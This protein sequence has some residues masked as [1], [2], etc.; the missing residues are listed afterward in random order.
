MTGDIFELLENRKVEA[1]VSLGVDE[2]VFN[3]RHQPCPVCGGKDR[4][5]WDE[6]YPTPAICNQCGK[7]GWVKFASDVCDISYRD[8]AFRLKDIYGEI[9]N[10]TV[11]KIDNNS[12]TERARRRVHKILDDPKPI[13][14]TIAEE[15]LHSR[16]L[17][18]DLMGEDYFYKP[19]LEYWDTS[20]PSNPVSKGHVPALVGKIRDCNGEVVGVQVTYLAAGQNGIRKKR[21]T[22]TFAPYRGGGI[23]ITPKKSE[24]IIVS[25]GLE[26]CLAYEILAKSG[27]TLVAALDEGGLCDFKPPEWVKSIEIL[28]D[29]DE[30]FVGQ[31]A[32]YILAKQLSHISEVR[33]RIPNIIEDRSAYGIDYCDLLKAS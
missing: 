32:A 18:I 31:A 30:S 17:S 6:K 11:T 29:P 13:A 10:T 16:N 12:S 19:L 7:K 5:R 15:Y 33:V 23:W 3:G 14:G 8:L 21:K 9:M 28:G 22:I 24:S 2:T 27:S 4:F 1:L 20:N 26:T 25:E